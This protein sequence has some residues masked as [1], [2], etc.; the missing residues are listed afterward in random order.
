MKAAAQL[1][2][3]TTGGHFLQRQGRHVQCV[4]VAGALV[5]AQE[6]AHRD[7]RREL[8]RPAAGR[9]AGVEGAAL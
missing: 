3:E 1:I 8:R 6:Q 2:V 7:V 5:M 9:R 4:G